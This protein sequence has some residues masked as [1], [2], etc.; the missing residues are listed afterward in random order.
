[1]WVDGGSLTLFRLRPQLVMRELAGGG[2]RPAAGA[3]Q[4]YTCGTQH[5]ARPGPAT[6][7]NAAQALE[8]VQPGTLKAGGGPGKREERERAGL[9]A[10][11]SC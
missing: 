6:R 1:M 3:L 9:E 8:P 7:N 11:V 10:W 5:K 4:H 2:R